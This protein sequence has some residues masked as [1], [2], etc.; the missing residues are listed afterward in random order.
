MNINQMEMHRSLY[1]VEC[2]QYFTA[3]CFFVSGWLR[4]GVR[5]IG[6]RDGVERIANERQGRKQTEKIV[7]LSKGRERKRKKRGRRIQS[8]CSKIKSDGKYLELF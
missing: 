8:V 1:V 5:K 4:K 2:E 7:V 3:A 6:R